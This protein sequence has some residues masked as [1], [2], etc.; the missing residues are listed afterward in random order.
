MVSDIRYQRLK[1]VNSEIKGSLRVKY[2]LA[3][4]LTI[5]SLLAIVLMAGYS[6]IRPGNCKEI[7]MLFSF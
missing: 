5:T 3:K 1:P 7:N 2:R 6:L 4:G